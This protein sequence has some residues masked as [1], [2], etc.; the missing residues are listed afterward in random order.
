MI[1]VLFD[2]RRELP[3]RGRVEGFT[4]WWRKDC[5][6]YLEAWTFA[7]QAL[8]RELRKW[9]NLVCEDAMLES[10]PELVPACRFPNEL[11]YVLADLYASERHG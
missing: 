5:A 4:G 11:D 10:E 8:E 3:W 2:P 1:R 6:T 7:V 9:P